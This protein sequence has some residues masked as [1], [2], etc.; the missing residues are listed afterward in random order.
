MNKKV[1]PFLV[2]LCFAQIIIGA[3][4]WW[5]WDTM[6]T[7]LCWTLYG[8]IGFLVATASL[9]FLYSPTDSKDDQDG[10][11]CNYFLA[12]FVWPIYFAVIDITLVILIIV[13][14]SKSIAYGVRIMFGCDD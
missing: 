8:S 2:F 13:N 11:W 7:T 14:I 6:T 9:C 12:L 3:I 4:W 5:K 1:I 10:L